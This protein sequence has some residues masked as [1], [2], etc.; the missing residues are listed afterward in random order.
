MDRIGIALKQRAPEGAAVLKAL[1]LWLADRKKRVN[2][3]DPYA[4][5][6]VPRLDVVIVL[7]G[8]GTLLSVARRIYGRET[9]IL[10]VN[11]GSL[12][13][14]TE[15][16]L[17]EVYA[18]LTQIFDAAY[19]TDPRMMLQG[20]VRQGRKQFTATALNDIVVHKGSFG[21]TIQ[22]DV[23]IDGAAVTTL[24]GD[25]LIISS[26]TG[27]TGYTLS[28]GGPIVHPSVEALVLTPITPHTLTN[29]PIVVPA[30]SEVCVAVKSRE[31]GPAVAFDGQEIFPLQTGDPVFVRAAPHRLHL[32]RSS[33]RNYYQV[34]REKLKWGTG[35]ES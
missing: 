16:A 11:M 22:L 7:G 17:D 10:A 14:L 2:L 21:R 31:A 9:P 25:G 33:N 29:R 19:E 26:A 6:P 4:K 15:V 13:F 27:S 1:R 30:S 18:S 5:T 20:V 23:Q 28:A 35:V 24:R 32:I 8:D 34:L 12:G 3:I